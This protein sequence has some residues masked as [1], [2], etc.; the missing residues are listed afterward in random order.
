MSRSLIAALPCLLLAA[1]GTPEYRAAKSQCMINLMEEY[2]P[3]YRERIVQKTRAVSV[4]NGNV[5]CK[6]IGN[7]TNCT[8]GKRTEYIP[9][10]VKETYDINESIREQRSHGCAQTRCLKTF[11][12]AKCE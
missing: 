1:C 4:P 6:R 12:N 7:P 8:Q 11:G 2:P 5:T 10:T 3:V 9:Y